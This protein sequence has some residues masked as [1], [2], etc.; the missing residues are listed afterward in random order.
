MRMRERHM[1]MSLMATRGNQSQWRA[2]A[3]LVPCGRPPPPGAPERGADPVAVL[4]R[5]V[6]AL[7]GSTVYG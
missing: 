3:C 5:R 1:T 6:K 7:Y 4:K 2:A